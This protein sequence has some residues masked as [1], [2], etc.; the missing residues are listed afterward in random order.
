M[1]KRQVLSVWCFTLAIM[2]LIVPCAFA[3]ILVSADGGSWQ[4]AWTANENG[5]PFWNN[6]SLDGP[7][8]NIGYFISYTGAFTSQYLPYAGPNAHLPYLGV[9]TTAD[10]N[11]YF[12]KNSTQSVASMKIE[13]AG[14]AAF[15]QFGYYDYNQSNQKVDHLIFDGSA[16]SSTL[17]YTFTPQSTKYGFYFVGK[18]SLSNTIGKWYTEGQG[19]HFAVFSAANSGVYWI[20]M[21]DLNLSSSDRDYNDMIVKVSATPVP[22]P[23]AVWL[24][25]TGL[26]GLVGIRRRFK[27]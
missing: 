25:G 6:S 23:A 19:D 21:E 22:I 13:I 24:L 18:S 12:Q 16:N 3:D 2:L 14:N 15:N 9:G 1:K 10:T 5:N 7:Q 11:F 26:L 17:P 8:K 20:G 27:Q 4:S